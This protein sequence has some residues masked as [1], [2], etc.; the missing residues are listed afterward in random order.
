MWKKYKIFCHEIFW[1][2]LLVIICSSSPQL[3]VGGFMSYLCFYVTVY[4]GL[5]HDFTIWET[6]RV[7]YLWK[8]LLNLSEPMSSPWS[9]LGSVLLI[10]L[11][12]CVVLG[13]VCL[14][15]VYWE[16]NVVSVSG[17]LIVALSVFPG[18]YLFK[19]NTHSTLYEQFR[20]L[21]K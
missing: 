4:S 13:F 1:W 14:R 20:N 9:L 19:I 7:Y 6:W 11:D 15:P 16:L 2:S 21:I 3:F 10:I 18:V 8:E 5:L 12:I 17:L